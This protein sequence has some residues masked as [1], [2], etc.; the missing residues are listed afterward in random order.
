MAALGCFFINI[1]QLF[2][3]LFQHFGYK[4]IQLKEVNEKKAMQGNGVCTVHDGGL[5]GGL[6]DDACF[7][8]SMAVE[9]EAEELDPTITT[10]HAPSVLQNT[11]SIL[12]N[13]AVK[14]KRVLPLQH[15]Q[16]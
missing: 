5:G 3:S 13:T 8:C 16:A 12:H 4:V 11:A 6:H 1:F 15:L 10:A 7:S 14:K 2:F 9:E